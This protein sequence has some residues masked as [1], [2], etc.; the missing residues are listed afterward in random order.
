MSRFINKIL[1]EAED[2]SDDFFQSKHVNKRI[3]SLRKKLERKRREVVSKI[4]NGLE[5]LNMIHE[6]NTLKDKKELWFLEAFS[7]LHIV[8]VYYNDEYKYGYFLSDSNDIKECFYDLKNNYFYIDYD[9]VDDLL[10]ISRLLINYYYIQSFIES[11]L[12]KY[13]NLHDV[14][15]AFC[16]KEHLLS[17]SNDLKRD[18]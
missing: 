18:K 12:K 9:F 8:D 11:M 3:E 4:K 7:K 5:S 10:I 14:H 13:F 15:V 16:S 1:R 17:L 2:S 6:N